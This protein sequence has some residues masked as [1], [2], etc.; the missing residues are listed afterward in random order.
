MRVA[1][2][3]VRSRFG[4]HCP[5]EVA[6]RA[7]FLAL[8]LL[9]F[10]LF[11]NGFWGVGKTDKIRVISAYCID[12]RWTVNLYDCVNSRRMC[13]GI[14]GRDKV[15]GLILEEFDADEMRALV[16]IRDGRFEAR[17]IDA[18]DPGGARN[19]GVPHD[20]SV[21]AALRGGEAQPVAARSEI[22]NVMNLNR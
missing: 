15:S 6:V 16:R 12:G 14:G 21:G 19:G 11:G 5:K 18:E 4:L 7:L 22:L 8:S 9:P 17:F 20:G 13:L 1:V 3:I 10:A 2:G